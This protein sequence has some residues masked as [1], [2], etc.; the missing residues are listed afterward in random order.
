MSALVSIWGAQPLSAQIHIEDLRVGFG[1]PNNQVEGNYKIGSWAPARVRLRTEKESFAGRLELSVAD[2]DDTETV[3]RRDVSLGP[4]ETIDVPTFVKPGKQLSEFQIRLLDMAGKTVARSSFDT[5]AGRLADGVS[6]D[7]TLIVTVGH[8]AGLN[9]DQLASR[10]GYPRDAFR[11]GQ[12]DSTRELSTRWFGYEAVDYLVLCLDDPLQIENMDL[13]GRSA[14]ETW[15][16]NGGQLVVSLGTS[17]E[18]VQSVLGGLLPAEIDGT[19]NVSQLKELESYVGPSAPA[20]A[21]RG[22]M[23]LPHMSKIRGQIVVGNDDSPLVVRAQVGFGTVTLVAL[24]LNREPFLSWEGRTDFWIKLLGLRKRTN[25]D[26]QPRGAWGARALADISSHLRM[27]LEQFA[28]V[29]LV[30]FQW[31]AFFIFIYI[32]LIGP[33]DYL[34]VKKLGRMELTWLTFPA[35]V[36]TVS[37]GAYFAAHYLKGDELRINKVDVVDIDQVSQQLRGTSWFT[38]FSPQIKNYTIRVQP[39]LGVAPEPSGQFGGPPISLSWLGLAEDAIG[40]MGRPGG[41]GL[42]RRGYAFGP[43][44]QTLIDVP[45]QVWSMKGFTA[46][47]HGQGVTAV[48]ADLQSV[49]TNRGLKGTVT[50]RLPFA[51]D[52]CML[53]FGRKVYPLGPLPASGSAIVGTRSSEDLGGHLSRRAGLFTVAHT[54][55]NS[56]YRESG[57]FNPQDL[58]FTM[59]FHSRLSESGNYAAND[60]FSDMDLADLLDLQRAILVARIAERGSRLFLND[61]EVTENVTQASYLR[62]VLPVT[63][64]PSEP[65]QFTPPATF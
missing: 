10:Q 58:V 35:W 9:V 22:N 15:V 43:D 4:N 65:L 41:V 25:Q 29:S 18:R 13:A 64:G 1:A 27:Q 38:L 53:V 42:F 61:A 62:V 28:G 52:D 32:L 49:D 48:A 2:S 60:Y 47:W 31:V 16:R 59:M 36:I 21:V 50:N 46:R 24:E 17:W 6:Q 57:E 3:F 34:L 37:L 30:P 19:V 5:S 23:S 14:M 26:T 54:Q 11:I 39:E 44:A 51:L 12:L 55:P 7:V 63:P 45:I 56:T 40:G 20:L 8:P 33:V